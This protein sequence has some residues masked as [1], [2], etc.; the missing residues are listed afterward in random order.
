MQGSVLSSARCSRRDGFPSETTEKIANWDPYDQNATADFFDPEWMFG[1]T[2]GFDVVI[3]NPPYIQLQKSGGTLGKLYKNA[4]FETFAGTGD[5]YCLFY[6]RGATTSRTADGYLCYI[7]SNKWMR[8][9]Y[10]KNLRQ[11][12][13]EN[14]HP[15]KLLDLGP[16]IFDATV[17]TNILLC[18]K[19]QESEI[20]SVACTVEAKWKHSATM[21]ATYTQENGVDFPM[22]SPGEQWVILSRIDRQIK[23]KIEEVGTPIREWDISIFQGVKTGYNAAF[24]IDNETKEI[25][26]EAH[27]KSSEIIKPVLRGRNIKG[28]QGDWAQL[29]LIDTH[30]GYSDVPAINVDNYGS[31]KAH[32]DK[33]YSRLEKRRDKGETPYNLRS[34]AYYP[35]FEQPKIVYPETTHAANFFY[36]DGSYF[37]EKT[38]FMI[39][40]SDLKMLVGL[41]SS[42]LMTFAYKQYYSGTVLGNKGYQYNKHALEKLPVVK[43][44]A[45]EQ[46]AFIALVDQ[47]L[48][49][50]AAH[51]DANTTDVEQEIDK[52]VYALYNLTQE[53]IAIVEETMQ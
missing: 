50:K 49:A 5:I 14:I 26:I 37:I 30:N 28:Y 34:C 9:G 32:L 43:I 23:A 44:P 31:V 41:L 29:W 22:P 48:K 19:K 42:T 27:P 11:F 3:G 7:T 35:A 15:K 39:T 53:E 24:L 18:S 46:P 40:G 4:G 36:D 25:L 13:V 52:R 1:I 20:E 21:L 47:I 10:G 6:E 38:C 33:F 17:D 16:D 51:P 12:F 45:S 2:D 8:A